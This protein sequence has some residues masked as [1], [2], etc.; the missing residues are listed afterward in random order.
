M[1]VPGYGLARA[2]DTG[3]GVKGKFVDLGF[4]DDD[5]QSWHWWTDIYLLTPVPPRSQD[6][7]GAARLSPVP[8]PEA[9][10]TRPAGLARRAAA[11]SQSMLGRCCAPTVCSPARGWGRT[12]S[13][14]R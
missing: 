2:G 4:S 14:I 3:G 12:F 6:P 9:A 13:S 11:M 10:M 8:R 5:Y 7:L 1:Y